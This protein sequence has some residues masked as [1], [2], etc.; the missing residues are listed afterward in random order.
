M[1]TSTT[2]NIKVPNI[3]YFPKHNKNQ[4]FIADTL[5]MTPTGSRSIQSFL[6]GDLVM[7]Y[8][9]IRQC[10][11]EV[12][13]EQVDIHIGRH[14]VLEL[15]IGKRSKLWVTLGHRFFNGNTWIACEDLHMVETATG[16]LKA[17]HA[18][19]T[20]TIAHAVYN[21]RTTTGTYLVGAE[22]AMTSGGKVA[23]IEHPVIEK[24]KQTLCPQR[25]MRR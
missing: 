18:Y 3:N 1:N 9:P 7:T 15:N 24:I 17:A 10:I 20:S 25:V 11:L 22:A 13:I 6:E 16:G 14:N 2:E 8:D 5:V 19:E 4:C 21:L 23:D 12:Q